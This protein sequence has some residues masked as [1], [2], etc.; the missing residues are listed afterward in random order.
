MPALALFPDR[1]PAFFRIRLPA[2]R[3]NSI[4]IL[5]F[6]F[7]RPLL[8]KKIIRLAT[9]CCFLVFLHSSLTGQHAALNDLLETR[10]F[11]LPD[12]T[13]EALPA[14]SEGTERYLLF[15][16]QPLDHQDTSAGYFYQRVILEHRG[17]DRP[18]LMNTNGY[19]LGGGLSELI[20]LLD[21]NFLNIEHRY[22]GESRPDSLDW[23]FLTLE[24]VTADLH[25]INRLFHDIYKEGP[26]VS[27]GISKGGQTSIYY[28][29]FY[30]DDVTVSMP[31]VAPLNRD[32]ED[33][34]I[35]AFLDSIGTD[36]CRRTIEDYQRALLT[37]KETLL[38]LLHWYA[39]G[40]G[41]TFQYL[42]G[43][44]SA[45]EYAVLEYPF[46]FWQWGADCSDIPD[47]SEPADSLLEHFIQVVGLGLYSDE[48]IRYYAPHYYQAASQMGYYG[49]ETGEFEGLLDAV[50][51]HPNAAFAPAKAAVQFDP[52]LNERVMEWVKTK[53]E[54]MIF[55]YGG[56]DTWSATG[57]DVAG[58]PRVRKFVV[59]GKHHG[60]ARINEMPL[61]MRQDLVKLLSDWLH[62]PLY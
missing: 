22:F 56:I 54:H 20:D 8:M 47:P 13:F 28:R 15:V 30:P 37:R 16:R 3:F 39:K 49:Y 48:Q 52:G 41:Q 1:F 23:R 59:P 61:S 27:A 51:E 40:K 31:Y 17:Y 55:I 19:A 33:P 2:I 44:E 57:V 9:F 36:Q 7:Q 11:N 46:S 53:A 58:N 10:L 50:P 45:F 14:E 34:R 38:P 5:S 18:V 21:A 60:N 43:L 4:E 35:Y 12:V 62:M 6:R 32:R 29:Y 24:Q 25:K 42:G 26:W